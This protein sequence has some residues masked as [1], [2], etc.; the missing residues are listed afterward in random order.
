[1]SKV[2][3][4]NPLS[5]SW[6]NKFYPLLFQVS[7]NIREQNAEG[8]EYFR[9]MNSTAED[10]YTKR[11]KRICIGDDFTVLTS[12]A[13]RMGSVTGR[14][15]YM[16]NREPQGMER[17]SWDINVRQAYDFQAGNN[18]TI[19]AFGTWMENGFPD[20]NE[21]VGRLVLQDGAT[22]YVDRPDL[23]RYNK[24]PDTNQLLRVRVVNNG[25]NRTW[26]TTCSVTVSRNAK[27]YVKGF[28]SVLTENNDSSFP[29]IT[30]E[31]GTTAVI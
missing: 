25:S 18:V 13:F 3:F 16:N 15:G 29:S 31:P 11:K 24:L 5:Y 7:D 26:P 17:L 14:W 19:T 9:P 23:F 30:V 21:N 28:T 2:P 6:K 4:A 10:F 22:L 27:L 12:E 8:E 1:M 20:S